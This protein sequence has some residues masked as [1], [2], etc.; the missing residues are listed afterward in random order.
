MYVV[1]FVC[2]GLVKEILASGPCIY[3]YIFV[4]VRPSFRNYN[5]S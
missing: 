4:F 3:I 1:C 5:Q 2:L